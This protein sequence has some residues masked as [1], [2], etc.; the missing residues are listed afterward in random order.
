ME[1]NRSVS[2]SFFRYKIKFT[3]HFTS[4]SPSGKN[5]K[6]LQTNANQK[7]AQDALHLT[8]D[9]DFFVVAGVVNSRWGSPRV[10]NR[11]NNNKNKM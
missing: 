11:W 2:L 7:K 1:P 3:L 9:F 6:R 4:L 10:S 5:K 8:C